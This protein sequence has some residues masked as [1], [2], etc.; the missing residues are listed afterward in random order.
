MSKAFNDALAV[1]GFEARDI[2]LDTNTIKTLMRPQS[3]PGGS[4]EYSCRGRAGETEAAETR[5]Q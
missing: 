3:A 4:H 2:T 5:P 1:A